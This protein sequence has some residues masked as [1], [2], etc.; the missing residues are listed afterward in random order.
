MSMVP[1]V[2]HPIFRGGDWW[3]LPVP[4]RI[5]NQDFGM[6]WGTMAPFMDATRQ[7]MEHEIGTSEVI[8]DKEKFQINMD[9]R[10]FKPE[11]ITVK[12]V[13]NQV[14]I[15]GKHEE[16][17]DPHGF[18]SRHFSRKYHLPKDVDVSSLVSTLSHE[19][20][21]S[22]KATKT[23][24]EGKKEIHIPIQMRMSPKKVA[25]EEKK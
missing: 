12:M 15:E 25:L 5:F 23:G 18:I 7:L 24:V 11:E 10:H 19:G 21:L 4:S 16:R 6:G 8:N 20:M 17:A 22:V 14:K 3:D 2:H 13:D 9:V 1:F